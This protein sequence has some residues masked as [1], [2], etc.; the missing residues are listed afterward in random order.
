MSPAG[1]VR[2]SEGLIITSLMVYAAEAKCLSELSILTVEVR[3]GEDRR[4]FL[5]EGD[6]ATFW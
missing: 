6:H 1:V 2:E 5:E 3:H 4:S